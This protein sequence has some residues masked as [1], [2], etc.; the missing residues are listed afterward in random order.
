MVSVV[1]YLTLPERVDSATMENTSG[2]THGD[3]DGD[4]AV[5]LPVINIS[6]STPEVGRQMID[7][8]SKHGFLY[9]DTRG[10]DFTPEIVE[11]QFELVSAHPSPSEIERGLMRCLVEAVLLVPARGESCMSDRSRCRLFF[12]SS[13]RISCGQLID[14][15]L[16][17]SQ[18]RGWSG[19]HSE[20]LDPAHQKVPSFMRTSER[21][22]SNN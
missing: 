14:A 21:L 8:A 11:R 6:D 15:E 16:Q 4:D 20:T 7:A 19:I 10:T 5:D 18:N 3:D 22:S 17:H 1:R 9:I 13:C 12:G 2:H